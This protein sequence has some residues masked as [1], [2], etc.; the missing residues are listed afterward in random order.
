MSGSQGTVGCSDQAGRRAHVRVDRGGHAHPR[1]R[2]ARLALTRGKG[3]GHRRGPRHVGHQVLPAAERADR[4]PG[5]ARVRPGAG[6]AAQGAAGPPPADALAQAET[7]AGTNPGSP[8]TP[9]TPLPRPGT[10]AGQ[11]GLEALLASPRQALVALDFDGTLSPVVG[12]PDDARAQPGA[13]PAIPALAQAV[14]TVAVITG[15]PPADAVRL[16]GFE[17]VPGL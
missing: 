13:V 6:Q 8:V 15:R 1:V 17:A 4:P 14:G 3:A 12:R 5:G 16:G 10:A 2:A 9:V 11:A 7:R